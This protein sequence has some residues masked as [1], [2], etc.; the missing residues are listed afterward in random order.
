[1]VFHVAFF[2]RIVPMDANT[3]LDFMNR[4]KAVKKADIG[5]IDVFMGKNINKTF[6][7]FDYGLV[8]TLKDQDALHAY[9]SHPKHKELVDFLNRVTSSTER[10]VVDFVD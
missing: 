1:M 6:T 4:V 9:L 8:I 10:A 3:E 7:Q 2:K 5:V